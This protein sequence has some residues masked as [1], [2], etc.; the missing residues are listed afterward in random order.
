MIQAEAKKNRN[1]RM[2]EE[3]EVSNKVALDRKG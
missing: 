1:Q 2:L 3:V